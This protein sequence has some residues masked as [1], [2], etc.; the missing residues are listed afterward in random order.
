M[1]EHKESD[2]RKRNELQIEAM[3][4]QEEARFFENGGRRNSPAAFAALQM[5]VRYFFT[6]NFL[7]TAALTSKTC[8][9]SLASTNTKGFFICNLEIICAWICPRGMG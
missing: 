8:E 9:C 2:I 7:I 4:V 5:S 1:H 3:G 6:Y